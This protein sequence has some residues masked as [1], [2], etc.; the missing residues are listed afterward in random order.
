[1]RVQLPPT[2]Q[3]SGGGMA[4][5]EVSKTSTERCESSIL[6]LSTHVRVVE[7]QTRW[8]KDPM[9]KGV[10]VQLSPRT[11]AIAYCHIWKVN[12]TRVQPSFENWRVPMGLWFESTSFRCNPTPTDH[13]CSE[14][15]ATQGGE[16]YF[17]LESIAC[18]DGQRPAKTPNQQWFGFDSHVFRR[19]SLRIP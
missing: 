10:R 19:Y 18:V 17:L 3:C 9:P 15:L 14:V 2:V 11:P 6:S 5:T 7:W 8:I 16:G 12:C 13:T 1:M 4:D